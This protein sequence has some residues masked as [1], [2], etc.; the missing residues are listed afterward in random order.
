MFLRNRK[1]GQEFKFDERGKPIKPKV[2]PEPAL[3]QTFFKPVQEDF[4]SNSLAG[5][6]LAY[7]F[8]DIFSREAAKQNI[9]DNLLPAITLAQKVPELL[10]KTYLRLTGAERNFINSIASG[11][12]GHYL[13]E[14]VL[15]MFSISPSALFIA[16]LLIQMGPAAA[17]KLGFTFHATEDSTLCDQMTCNSFYVTDADN[18]IVLRGAQGQVTEAS[19]VIADNDCVTLNVSE[20]MLGAILDA[21]PSSRSELTL[22]SVVNTCRV[23]K[24]ENV[25]V[26]VGVVEGTW[27]VYERVIVQGLSDDECKTLKSNFTNQYAECEATAREELEYLCSK[28]NRGIMYA[29]AGVGVIAACIILAC[30]ICQCREKNGKEVAKKNQNNNDL[31]RNAVRQGPRI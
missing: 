8:Y 19:T 7:K 17:Q 16:S 26:T 24:D 9:P 20:T 27:R 11:M 4:N 14:P 18:K 25:S 23:D 31:E 12:T 29:V 28:Q 3:S 22:S 1:T 2:L 13:L 15:S 10:E 5:I 6:G 21:G 30:S